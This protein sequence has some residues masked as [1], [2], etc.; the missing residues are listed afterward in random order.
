MKIYL[1]GGAVRDELM[2]V[3]GSDRDW[4]VV[5]ATPEDLIFEG[6]TPVGKDFPVFLHPQTGEEYA[7]AR[8]ERKTA[9]GYHGFVFHADP[10]ITL[11]E[12]LA[13]RDLTIN[14]IAKDMEG[15]LIDPFKGVDDIKN[16]IFRHVSPAFK[17]D[18]VRILRLARFAARYPEFTTASETQALLKQMCEDGEVDAL[19]SERIWQEISKGLL[20]PRPFR[21]LEVLLDCGALVRLFP[22]INDNKLD[23]AHL[24]GVN[25]GLTKASGLNASLSVRFA[26]LNFIWPVSNYLKAPKECIELAELLKNLYTRI[27]CAPSL[28]SLD[29]LTLLHSGDALRRPERFIELLTAC[30]CISQFASEQTTGSSTSKVHQTYQPKNFLIQMLD[31]TLS[32]DHKNIAAKAIKEGLVATQIGDAIDKARQEAIEAAIDIAH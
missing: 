10:S 6:Y 14:A 25:W 5:G 13:R 3:S 21:M 11:E 30:E 32:I 22:Q 19:V 1:V 26:V 29:I 18:P 7:L 9:P 15:Q 27:S 4:V 24:F 20:S 31:A 28:S 12:D 16:R 23:D 2:G 8:T 17:E